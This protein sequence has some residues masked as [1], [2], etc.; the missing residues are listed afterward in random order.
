MQEES[1]VTRRFRQTMKGSFFGDFVYDQVVPRDHFLMQLDRIIDWTPFTTM[2]VE[3]YKGKA[4]RGEVPYDP[5]VI[6]KMLFLTYLYNMSERQIEDYC[7]FYLPAKAFIGLGVAEKAPD[8]STLTVFKVRLLEK[9]GADAFAKMF[10]MIIDQARAAGVVFGKVQLVDATHTVADVNVEKDRKRHEQGKPLADPDAEVVEKGTREVTKPDLTTK[11]EKV[12]H[13]GYKTHVSMDAE[14]GIVTSIKPTMGNV[15]DKSQMPDLVKH[16][17][18]MGIPADTYVADRGYDDGDLHEMLWALKKH[19][20]LKLNDIRTQ[21]KDPNKEPWL[22]L[23]ADSFYKA[24][25][26]LRYR[27][28]RKFGEAKAWHHLNRCRYRGLDRFKIQSYLTFMVLNIKRTVL[29]VTNTRLR[30]L[31]KHLKSAHGVT[32]PIA[33]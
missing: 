27:I 15:D 6:L 9:D 29:L 11:V 12:I 4:E 13:R 5:V 18:K 17:A 30:P 1:A 22:T 26:R 3:Y 25:L 20:A 2:L 19:S 7:N 32:A 10:D 28:E 14:S 24:G 23:I 8:H 31:A 21:K 16:D 33:G